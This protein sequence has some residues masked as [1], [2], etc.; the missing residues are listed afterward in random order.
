LQNAAQIL[1]LVLSH[2]AF[3]VKLRDIFYVMYS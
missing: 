2:Q 3:F 1:S